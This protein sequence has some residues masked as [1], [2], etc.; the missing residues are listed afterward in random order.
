MQQLVAW[1]CEEETQRA[2]DEDEK[3][4]IKRLDERRQR[5]IQKEQSENALLAFVNRFDATDSC[6]KDAIDTPRDDE[7]PSVPR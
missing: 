5:Q 2:R 6:S 3:Q 7:F 1:R 4:R